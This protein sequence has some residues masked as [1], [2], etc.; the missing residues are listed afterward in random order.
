MGG[1]LERDEMNR[2]MKVEVYS[3]QHAG[4]F[5]HSK[6]KP[7]Y[8]D[9]RDIRVCAHLGAHTAVQPTCAKGSQ[10]ISRWGGETQSQG[11]LS[12][13]SAIHKR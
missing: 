3:I 4:S 2:E 11:R 10:K 6:S 9:V 13:A 7:A 12:E 8:L 1:K 5:T